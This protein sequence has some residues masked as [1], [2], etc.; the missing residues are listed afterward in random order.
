[1]PHLSYD[2]LRVSDRL[3]CLRECRSWVR[4]KVDFGFFISNGDF[5]LDLCLVTWFSICLRADWALCVVQAA[6]V[7]LAILAGVAVF[8]A[9]KARAPFTPQC[10]P[11]SA[12]HTP[13]IGM[14]IALTTSQCKRKY[15]QHNL[16]LLFSQPMEL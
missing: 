14:T 2:G 10:S 5:R 7:V 15:W 4:L 9:R 11:I 3:S 1:M 13:N 12:D 16:L 8:V 6:V